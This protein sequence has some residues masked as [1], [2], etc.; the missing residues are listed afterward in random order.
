MNYL[1]NDIIICIFMLSDLKTVRILEQV[2]TSFYNILK[3]NDNIWKYI[4][5]N[6]WG[7][8]FFTI[9]KRRTTHISK[10]LL[11]Y[12]DELIRIANFEKYINSHWNMSQYYDY[13]YTL[14]L[15]HY[16]HKSKKLNNQYTYLNKGLFPI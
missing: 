13:W 1:P 8:I 7:D 16:K 12:R 3:S 11:S 15:I 9:A 2:C 6:R 4:S 14:E 5:D 10:P